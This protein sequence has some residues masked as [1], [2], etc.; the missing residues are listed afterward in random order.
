MT[1]GFEG[2]VSGWDGVET[3]GAEGA[4]VSGAGSDGTDDSGAAGMSGCLVGVVEALLFAVI[5]QT[6]PS[7]M[8]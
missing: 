8:A 4:V 5:R 3:D 6:S 7:V 1:G 2:A